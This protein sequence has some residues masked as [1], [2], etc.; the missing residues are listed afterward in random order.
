[1]GGLGRQ[2]SAIVDLVSPEQSE[3]E[4]ADV[5]K[6]ART[7]FDRRAGAII[8]S[9]KA[10]RILWPK[11]GEPDPSST[12]SSGQ[13]LEQAK[14]SPQDSVTTTAYRGPK[15]ELA[16][17]AS[18]TPTRNETVPH[19]RV[20]VAAVHDEAD[21]QHSWEKAQ[22]DY[23]AILAGMEPYIVR[24]ETSDGIIYQ[25]QTGP[26]QTRGEAYQFC[27]RLRERGAI[28]FVAAV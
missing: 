19:F 13:E 11:A 4:V 24:A 5:K 28:C 18:N 23:G 21:A 6:E 20:Q 7:S 17:V 3:L 22:A 1:V 25:I 27:A 12:S 14:A 26:F 10:K 16:A 15:V 8:T 9:Q 2:I